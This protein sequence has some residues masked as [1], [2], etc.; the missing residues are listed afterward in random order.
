MGGF[1]PVASSF[2]FWVSIFILRGKMKDLREDALRYPS[3][4][5]TFLR[6]LGALVVLVGALLALDPRGDMFAG[7]SVIIGGL[8]VFALGSLRKALG[9]VIFELRAAAKPVTSNHTAQMDG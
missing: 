3:A 2:P 6:V 4:A 7:L 9:D 8:I 1:K 5:A